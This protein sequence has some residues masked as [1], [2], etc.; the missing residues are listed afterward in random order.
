MLYVF[1]V[2]KYSNISAQ[3]FMKTIVQFLSLLLVLTY[4]APLSA[5]CPCKSAV[6][7]QP[8]EKSPLCGTDESMVYEEAPVDF[9]PKMEVAGCYCEFQGKILFLLRNPHKAQGNT[10]CVPGGK[11]EKQETPLAAVLR[12]VRE[13]TGL[14]LS[15]DALTDCGSV[16]VRFPNS[17]II[18]YLFRVHLDVVPRVLKISRKENIAYRWLSFDEAMGMH[19]IPG[20][21]ECLR[22]V[23]S[24]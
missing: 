9:N 21:K 8:Q 15:A 18:L 2:S 23:F 20:G 6:N 12:E 22:I 19:L 13:E 3:S 11:L 1:S 17:D 16:F 4:V 7:S 10:W 14:N 5:E 24:R